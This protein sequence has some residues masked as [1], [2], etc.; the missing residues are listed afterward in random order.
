MRS[1]STRII[2]RTESPG[3][4]FR[5]V[6]IS[7]SSYIKPFRA[8]TSNTV[9]AGFTP[10]PCRRFV[11]VNDA[12]VVVEVG[13]VKASVTK[14][15]EYDDDDDDDANMITAKDRKKAAIIFAATVGV[16]VVAMLL[17]VTEVVLLLLLVV[18]IMIINSKIVNYFWASSLFC[19]VVP[20]ELFPSFDFLSCVS[21]QWWQ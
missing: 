8:V 11:T 15:D 4:I 17:F 7:I 10:I 14:I 1:S 19:Y 3:K 5:P 21:R 12:V 18:I 13:V 16:G 2:S 9:N 6:P 20:F